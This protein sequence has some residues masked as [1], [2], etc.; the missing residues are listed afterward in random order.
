MREILIKLFS[1]IVNVVIQ[2]IYDW[3][4]KVIYGEY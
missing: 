1:A 4:T 3:Q 2:G